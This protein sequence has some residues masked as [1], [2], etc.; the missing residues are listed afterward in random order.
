MGVIQLDRPTFLLRHL[1]PAVTRLLAPARDAVFLGLLS[2][3]KALN[4]KHP[5]VV[6]QLWQVRYAVLEGEKC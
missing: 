1:F 5:D 3:L 4:Q 6:E 2:D